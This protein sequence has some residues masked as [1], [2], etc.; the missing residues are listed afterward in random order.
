M[1]VKFNLT[2]SL[3][4]LGDEWLQMFSMGSSSR[5]NLMD[6]NI[7]SRFVQVQNIDIK[8]RAFDYV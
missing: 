3:L 2:E 8:T 7:R 1:L 4:S 6:M 5:V